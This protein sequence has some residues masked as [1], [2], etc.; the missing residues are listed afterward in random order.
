MKR[1]KMNKAFNISRKQSD[2]LLDRG[3]EAL[4]L[5]RKEEEETYNIDYPYDKEEDFKRY[6][7]LNPMK[8]ILRLFKF[9][10]KDEGVRMIYD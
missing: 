1:L 4:E 7:E 2:L 3:L 6:H 8:A 9:G 10:L 5:L